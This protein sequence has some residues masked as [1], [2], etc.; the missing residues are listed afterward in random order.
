[1]KLLNQ[2]PQSSIMKTKIPF[3]EPNRKRKQ[4]LFFSKLTECSKFLT[5]IKHIIINI[6]IVFQTITI[7]VSDWS[8]TQLTVI[9]FQ[10][11]NN[12]L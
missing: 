12:D 5:S 11:Y 4:I 7:K 1:M 8:F 3:L 9:K 2:L 6:L 10:F